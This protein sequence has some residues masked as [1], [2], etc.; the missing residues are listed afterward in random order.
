MIILCVTNCP[1]ALR[2]D[3]S[4]WLSEI[5]TGVYVGKLSTRVRE[6]LWD[7]VCSNMK[8]GQATM[9]YSANTEQGY[10]FL[11]HNTTW[12]PID[13]EGITLMQ[14]PLMQSD[15]MG[16]DNTLPQGFSKASKYE[17]IKHLKNNKDSPEY[18]VVDVET[19]G[20]DYDRDRIVEVALIRKGKMRLWINSN[21]ILI[22]ERISRLMWKGRQGLQTAWLSDRK[23]VRMLHLKKSVNLLVMI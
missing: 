23:S 15:D 10:A 9:V 20:L 1:P 2:G 7:R 11:V 14:K 6:E 8:N 19:T 3:L 22:P 13:F 18:V 12:I 21:V 17:K 5:N 16:Q 4:K